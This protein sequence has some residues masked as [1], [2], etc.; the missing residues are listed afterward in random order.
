MNTAHPTDRGRRHHVLGGLALALALA[1]PLGVAQT[2]AANDFSEAE[3]L[4]FVE[5]QLANIKAPTSLRYAFVRSGPLEPGFEDEVRIDVLKVGSSGSSV[6]G[7]F[8]SGTRNL[9][10]PDISDAK[11]NPVI[12]YFLEHD[13]RE[14]ARLTKRKTGNYFRNRIRKTLVDEA[15]VRD[16]TVSYEGRDVPAREVTLKPYSS[17]PARSRY[18]R[19]AE[20]RYTFLLSNAVPGGVYQLR[21]SLPGEKAG[22]APALEEVMTFAGPMALGA[23]KTSNQPVKPQ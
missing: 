13:I 16:T 21:T 1:A 6:H 7:D 4:V 22:E 11:A 5:H 18:E 8:L 19:Y 3:K 10:L 9:P 14:M 17:D 12:L 23:S 15:Q 20:K 2:P